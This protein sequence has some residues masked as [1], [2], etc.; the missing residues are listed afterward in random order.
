MRSGCTGR[1]GERENSGLSPSS[2][3]SIVI[4]DSDQD[5]GLQMKIGD[6]NLDSG[7]SGD[8]RKQR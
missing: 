6:G 7:P 1:T 8:E 2:V 3:A 4:V 5:S